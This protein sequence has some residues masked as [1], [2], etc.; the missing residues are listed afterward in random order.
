M[1]EFESALEAYELFLSHAD[2][3]VNELEI[4]KVKLRLPLLK[5]QIKLGQ[6]TKRKPS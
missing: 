4:E 5:R 1:G 3:R 2:A 6:G